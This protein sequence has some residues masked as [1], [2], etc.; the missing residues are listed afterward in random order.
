MGVGKK[1]FSRWKRFLAGFRALLS[2][3]GLQKAIARTLVDAAKDQGKFRFTPSSWCFEYWAAGTPGRRSILDKM[4]RLRGEYDPSQKIG[5]FSWRRSMPAR[6][7]GHRP[8]RVNQ[9]V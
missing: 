2:E 8:V 6:G 1:A 9:F 4:Q 5:E 7:R 3:C